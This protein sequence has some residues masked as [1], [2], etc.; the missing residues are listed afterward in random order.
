M[1]AALRTLRQIGADEA[2]AALV[3]PSQRENVKVRAL[4]ARFR[5]YA[6][7][8]SPQASTEAALDVAPPEA[9]SAGR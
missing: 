7:G 2:L 4:A 6:T 5:A 9:G 3:E 1:A 8:A